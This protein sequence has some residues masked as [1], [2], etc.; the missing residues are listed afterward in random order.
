MKKYLYGYPISSAQQ[1]FWKIYKMNPGKSTDNLAVTLKI[2]GR[3]DAPLF[4]KTMRRV[5]QQYEI[6]RTNI[7]EI[8]RLP[9]QVISFQP[10]IKLSLTDL[11]RS[12]PKD[13]VK[14]IIKKIINRPFKLEHG[15]LGQ[16]EL[17][18]LK[19]R[20]FL[21][22]VS[23]H[24]IIADRWSLMLIFEEIINC[25][26]SSSSGKPAPTAKPIIQYK[27]YTQWE[28]SR[29]NQKLLNRQK[30]YWL[31]LF[32]KKITVL[33]LAV[34]SA[35]L[36]NSPTKAKPV[37]ERF[38]FDKKL[39]RKIKSFCK[40]HNLTL[41]NFLFTAFNIFLYRTT[42]QKD[43]IILTLSIR[44][45]RLETMKTIGC[46]TDVIAV[47]NFLEKDLSFFELA[48][49]IQRNLVASFSNQDYPISQLEKE[50]N[51]KISDP[52]LSPL[53]NIL[54]YLCSDVEKYKLKIAHGKI[55][56]L[57]AHSDLAYYDQFNLKIQIIDAGKF[58]LLHFHHN[59]LFDSASIKHWFADYKN[60]VNFILNHPA[61]KI[62]D[63]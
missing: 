40:N 35:R 62:G 42:G 34:S 31:N 2:S 55:E 5:V 57:S 50:I 9:V 6:L 16:F 41:F 29:S 45:T 11:A 39:S 33:N 54:F 1:R 27:D 47:R 58:F 36:P 63:F 59:N 14:A 3:L 38:E 53:K 20:Q 19:D 46:F 32:S 25:Y 13:S 43:L 30:K 24:P 7:V 52:A 8:N 18:K 56:T 22:V 60:C 49:A 61:A 12:T 21:L 4:V 23:I 51:K 44:R 17:L 37:L 28:R 48:T 26:N 15:M 10:R